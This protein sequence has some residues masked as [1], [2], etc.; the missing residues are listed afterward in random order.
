VSIDLT[1]VRLFIFD[2]DGTLRWTV[3]PGQK[4]PLQPGDWRLMPGVAERLRR[5]P[6]GA[7][8]P[9]LAIASN[10]NGVAA[11]EL[12]EETARALL[13]DMLA[14]ALG[15]VPPETRIG[16]CI[17]DE[18]LSCECRK[19]APGLLL[20]HLAHFGVAPREA[21]FVGD[22]DI[23]EEAARRA[24]IPFLRAQDFFGA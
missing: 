18:R 19:P 17:C 4:Y 2:A 15:H 1:Q 14:E 13:E 20:Q 9:W 3:V 11:G 22:L 21:L 10:Q 7:E 24:G 8:G 23:D 12:S 16:M 5:I 6:F